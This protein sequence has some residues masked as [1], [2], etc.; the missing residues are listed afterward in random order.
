MCYVK[1]EIDNEFNAHQSGGKLFKFDEENI[2]FSLGDFHLRKLAQEDNTPFGKI[3]K[4]NIYKLNHE[5]LSKGHRNP[6][7]LLYNKNDFIIS[8]EHGTHGGDEINLNLN[9]RKNVKNFVGQYH[10]METLWWKRFYC[11]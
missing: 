4:I 2:I 9:T 1:G 5:I 11:K 3:V 10:L 7:G 8:T 6:Q